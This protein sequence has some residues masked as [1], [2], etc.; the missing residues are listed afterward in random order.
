MDPKLGVNQ[1]GA[2]LLSFVKG[3][4]LG[5]ALRGFASRGAWASQPKLEEM[6]VKHHHMKGRREGQ[7]CMCHIQQHE[8]TRRTPVTNTVRI[9][10]LR[11]G[12][13]EVK[14]HRKNVIFFQITQPACGRIHVSSFRTCSACRFGVKIKAELQ[15]ETKWSLRKALLLVQD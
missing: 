13:Q 11:F 6:H 12:Q 15:V 2:N 14:K 5:S 1:R 7:V 9:K 10:L 8:L 3:P 4:A